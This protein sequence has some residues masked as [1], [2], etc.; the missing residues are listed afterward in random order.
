MIRGEVLFKGMRDTAAW[1]WLCCWDAIR[2]ASLCHKFLSAGFAFVFPVVAVT[3]PRDMTV[4][5]LPGLSQVLWRSS[6]QSAVNNYLVCLDCPSFNAESPQS[7]KTPQSQANQD[8]WSP[9]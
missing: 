3:S 5:A 1:H 6:L 4:S 8:N 7:C 9:Y 2:E